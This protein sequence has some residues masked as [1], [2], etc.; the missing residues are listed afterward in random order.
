MSDLD[1]CEQPQATQQSVLNRSGKDKF[2]LVLNL[3]LV[4]RKQTRT[5]NLIDLKPLEISVYGSVVPTIQ[6]PPVEVRFGGQSYNVS[7]YS[8]PNYP[9]LTVNFVVDNNFKNYWLLWKWLSILNDPRDS[10]YAGHKT[11]PPAQQADKIEAGN[12]IEYQTNISVFG[13]NEYNQKTIEFLYFNAFITSL[14]GIDYNYRTPELLESTVEFQYSQFDA[15]LL[16][17]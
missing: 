17:N 15:N 4:L 1:L 12:L 6:V 16:I 3:P 5:N 14:G 8:R 9:P 11:G 13:L 10:D 7:S 2:L